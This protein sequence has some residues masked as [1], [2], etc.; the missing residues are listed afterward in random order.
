MDV[1]EGEVKKSKYALKQER[2]KKEKDFG[3][4][5]LTSS[6]VKEEE[7]P[8]KKEVQKEIQHSD[9]ELIQKWEDKLQ[10]NTEELRRLQSKKDVIIKLMALIQKKNIRLKELIEETKSKYN[11]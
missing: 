6:E 1:R 8:Q 9:L 4:E 10:K 7:K 2:L 5:Y 3:V 11:K